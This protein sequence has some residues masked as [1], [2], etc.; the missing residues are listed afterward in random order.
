LDSMATDSTPISS[1]VLGICKSDLNKSL[2]YRSKAPF[3]S[4]SEKFAKGVYFYS[5]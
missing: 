5:L 3:R 2:W 4:S 1:H